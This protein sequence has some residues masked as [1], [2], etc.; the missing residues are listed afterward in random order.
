MTELVLSIFDPNT[1]LPHRAGIAGLALALSAI[2][3]TDAPMQWEVTED[4]V[5][6]SW[7]GSDLKAIQWLLEQTYQIKRGL[8]VAPALN[9]DE[10]GCFTFNQGMLSSF[11]QHGQQKSFVEDPNKPKQ[12]KKKFYKT[13]MLNFMIEPDSPEISV[14]YTLLNSCYYTEAAKLAKD[15]SSGKPEVKTQILPGLEEC[16]VNGSYKESASNFLALL[17]LPL[18]CGYYQLPA[19]NGKSRSA[20]VIPE[21]QNLKVWVKL[22]QKLPSK[23]Y[24]NFGSPYGKFR[25]SSAG[26]AALRFLLDERQLDDSLLFKVNYCEVYQLGSQPWNGN[27]SFIKQAVYRVPLKDDALSLYRIAYQNLKPR[28][29]SRQDGE[30]TWLAESKV[31]AWISDNLIAD[32]AWYSGFFEFRKATTIYPEDRRGLVVM[33]E[34][35]NADEQVLFDAVQGAFSAFLRDQI[36]QAQKQGRSLDYGQVTDKVIYRLQ[37]PSTQQEFATALVDFL[38]QFRSKAARAAGPQIF[39]WIHQESNWRKA[40]DLTLLAIATYKGKTKE[41]TVLEQDLTAETANVL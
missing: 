25:A 7:E 16:F 24:A 29:R 3:P 37:R 5:K 27:Q 6:L 17:F 31:L 20:I 21:I 39:W 13:Q 40:R 19:L 14:S 22:R 28:L 23:V 30:G 32:K 34:H 35:L 4:A 11:L 26:E 10:Q 1:L 41:E 12:G 9:L 38:S 36:Q 8:L 2:A 15:F 18:A 33:T